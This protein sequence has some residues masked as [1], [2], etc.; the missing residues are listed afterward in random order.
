MGSRL[1][2]PPPGAAASE[3]SPMGSTDWQPVAAFPESISA[4]AVK[5]LLENSGVPATLR[6]DT[7]I[8][9]EARQCAVLVPT[10]LLERARQVLAEQQDFTEAELEF[11]ATGRLGCADSRE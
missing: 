10:S 4:A 1:R 6:S 3:H 7:A 9:G 8:L 5:A 2:S 11:L